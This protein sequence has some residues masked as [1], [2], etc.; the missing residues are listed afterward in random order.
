MR[1]GHYVLFIL[2]LYLPCHFF[3]E[4][5]GNFPKWL[6]RHWTPTQLSYGHWMANNI[7]IFYP[8]LAAAYLIYC[9]NPHSCAFLGG[10][11]LV[12][13]IINCGDHI[14]YTIKDQKVSP[15][16]FTGGL[17]ALDAALGFRSMYLYETYSMKDLLLSVL[18]GS[19]L[20]GLPCYLSMKIAPCFSRIF[21]VGT[22]VK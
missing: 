20:F 22:Q 13:G 1:T 9:F 2:F 21:G 12:W 8:M 6:Y 14:F 18:I 16:L 7:F 15:G 3:E 19:F 5:M 10:G 11:L 4:A 17:Y